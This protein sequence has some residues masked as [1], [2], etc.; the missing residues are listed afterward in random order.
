MKYTLGVTISSSDITEEK[1]SET[2][3]TAIETIYNVTQSEIKKLIGLIIAN[4]S[5]ASPN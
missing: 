1:I 2:K 5:P 4:M 3:D